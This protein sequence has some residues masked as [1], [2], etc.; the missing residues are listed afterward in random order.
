MQ[1]LSS[2]LALLL[3]RVA[4][5]NSLRACKSANAKKVSMQGVDVYC[6][7]ETE[8]KVSRALAAVAKFYGSHWESVRPHLKT[9]IIDEGILTNLWIPQRTLIISKTDEGRMSSVENLAG[10]LIADYERIDVLRKKR[11]HIIPWKKD[12]LS[13]ASIDALLRRLD[14]TEGKTPF[15]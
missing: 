5:R 4:I 10:W 9:I 7:A 12:A 11:C 1:I 6:R 8:R 13:L 3:G 2:I 15:A 14:Y